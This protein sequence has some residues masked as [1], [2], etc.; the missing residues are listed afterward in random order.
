MDHYCC[1]SGADDLLRPTNKRPGLLPAASVQIGNNLFLLAFAFCRRGH[2]GI[3][4]RPDLRSRIPLIRRHDDRGA[5]EEQLFLREDHV[6]DTVVVYAP[7]E[8]HAML[9]PIITI[10][11]VPEFCGTTWHFIDDI[12]VERADHNP[13]VDLG[14]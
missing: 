7:I 2:L 1:K 8:R 14:R 4:N 12:V 3:T 11:G 10:V 6:A 9:G 5:H 13:P